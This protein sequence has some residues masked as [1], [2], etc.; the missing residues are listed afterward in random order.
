MLGEE[1]M[2]SVANMMLGALVTMVE[3]GALGNGE[4]EPGL[5]GLRFL[6]GCFIARIALLIEEI[7]AS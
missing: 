2:D 5:L 1:E 7:A 4:L 6:E 3:C